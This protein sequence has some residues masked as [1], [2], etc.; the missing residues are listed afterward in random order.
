MSLA[1]R[2]STMHGFTC[3]ERA[4]P[5]VLAHET[6]VRHAAAATTSNHA[7]CPDPARRL[8]EATSMAHLPRAES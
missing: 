8:A 7:M 1:A 4:G 3:S 6:T 2:N 5:A